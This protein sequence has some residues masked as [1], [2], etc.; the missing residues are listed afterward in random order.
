MALDST[1]FGKWCVGVLMLVFMVV[2][3]FVASSA[4]VL[5][6]SLNRLRLRS[7]SSAGS[8]TCAASGS[9]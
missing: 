7:R 5:I 4:A 3:L 8:L 6:S 9:T 1:R 2:L